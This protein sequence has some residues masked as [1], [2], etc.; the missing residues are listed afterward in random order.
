MRKLFNVVGILILS[1]CVLSCSKDED[2]PLVPITAEEVIGLWVIQEKPEI[3][4]SIV[5]NSDKAQEVVSELG[6]LFQKGDKYRFNDDLTCSITRG[7]STAGP[8][9][10]KID[11]GHLVFDGYIKFLTDESGD[12]LTLTAG[13]DE[14]REIVKEKVKDE[15]QGEALDIVLSAVKGSIKIV[16][17][18]E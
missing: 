12:M 1:M 3:S 13:N 14:I 8:S 16:L 18:K 5:G 6:V 15:Y 2:P 17:Q 11:G 10:Y 7:N 9:T 4:I